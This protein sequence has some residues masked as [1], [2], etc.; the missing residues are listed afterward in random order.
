LVG[1]AGRGRAPATLFLGLTD[2]T[3]VIDIIKFM[4]RFLKNEKST[5][6]IV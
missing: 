5:H 3:L 2:H 6:F 1:N 4:L